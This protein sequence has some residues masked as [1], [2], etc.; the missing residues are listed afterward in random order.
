ML[1]HFAVPAFA[2]DTLETPANRTVVAPNTDI[3]EGENETV[4][5]LELPGV[6]RSAIKVTFDRGVLTVTAERKPFEISEKSRFLMREQTA[7]EFRRSVRVHHP[8]EIGAMT[9]HLEHGILRI[10]MPKAEIAKPRVIEVK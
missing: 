7:T 10:T 4:A 8:V 5:A 3:M 6:E 1:I 2:E 9:A